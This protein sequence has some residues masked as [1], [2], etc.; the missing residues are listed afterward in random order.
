MTKRIF[1]GITALVMLLA[2]GCNG[3]EKTSS[4]PESQP[5]TVVSDIV[6]EPTNINPLTG[7]ADLENGAE[8]YK[9]V[10]IMINNIET[11]WG[12]QTSLSK[13]DIIYETYVEG[14]I[15]RCMAVFKDIRKIGDDKIGSL[16]SGRYSYVDLALGTGAQ[17]VHAGLDEKYCGPYM[18]ELGIKSVDLNTYANSENRYGG[19]ECAFR[20]SN[21]LSLE[22]TLYTTGNKLFKFLN[23]NVDIKLSKPQEYWMNFTDTAYTPA[24]GTCSELSVPFSGSYTAAFKYNE[25]TKKYD[26]YR[27]GAVQQDYETQNNVSVNNVLVLYSTVTTFS[28]NKHVKTDLTSGSGYYISNGG[29]Q[30]INWAKGSAK[31]SIKITDESGKVIDYNVGSTYV[32]FTNRDNQSA[33]VIK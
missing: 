7:V 1:A 10:A 28:D 6:T 15:T 22:H 33:T 9:P 31:E 21:G 11:A 26:K 24:G 32:C 8:N 25:S 29:Y 19:S 4:A 13:A 20:H 27:Y 18:T 14:G 5:Q 12:V 23:D 3:T 17:F 2:S 30:K 16:R